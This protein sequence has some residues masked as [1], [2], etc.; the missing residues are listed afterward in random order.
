[1]EKTHYNI[2][3]KGKVQGVWF[4]KYTKEK[5]DKLGVKGFVKNKLN[6]NVYVEA[7]G[8][9]IDLKAFIEWLYVGSP[10]SIVSSVDYTEGEFTDFQ[11]FKIKR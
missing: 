8:Y 9:S 10:M 2:I 4:R 1:M 7:E 11:T 6:S 5:A 3:V